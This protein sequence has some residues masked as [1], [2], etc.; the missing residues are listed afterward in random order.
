MNRIVDLNQKT[1]T[2]CVPAALATVEV[3]AARSHGLETWQVLVNGTELCQHLSEAQAN[4]KAR[5]FAQ[6]IAKGV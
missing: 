2:L 5:A 4:A 6:R 3:K 1:L